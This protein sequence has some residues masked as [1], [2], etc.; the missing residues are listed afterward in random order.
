MQEICFQMGILMTGS[1]CGF[2]F[3]ESTTSSADDEKFTTVRPVPVEY[4]K[5]KWKYF[6]SKLTRREQGQDGDTSKKVPL[7]DLFIPTIIKHKKG[8]NFQMNRIRTILVS[9]F[10]YWLGNSIYVT[11]SRKQISQC[12]VSAIVKKYTQENRKKVTEK[13]KRERHFKT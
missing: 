3:L 12:H 9:F 4:P 1:V 7:K 2:E 5:I 8:T 6:Y 13:N 10:Y 11:G